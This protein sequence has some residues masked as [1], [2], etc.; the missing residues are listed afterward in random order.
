MTAEDS[1]SWK[2]G[3]VHRY[4]ATENLVNVS[5]IREN[6]TENPDDVSK[7]Q[8]NGARH[9]GN[10]PVKSFAGTRSRGNVMTNWYIVRENQVHRSAYR[11]NAS[12]HQGN[13]SENQDNVSRYQVD[14]PVN[15]DTGTK[16]Q[17]HVTPTRGNVLENSCNVPDHLG[18][19]SFPRFLRTLHRCAETMRSRQR[20]NGNTHGS[21][22]CTPSSAVK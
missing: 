20:G 16:N 8:C 6:A 9:R 4:N 18:D 13:G 12:E 19:V 21:R 17:L 22:P 14:G 5:G 15:H 3:F 1:A 11:G 10:L 2:D 7:H